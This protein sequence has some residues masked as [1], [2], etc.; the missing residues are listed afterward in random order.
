MV[1]GVELTVR[2]KVRDSL[3][4]AMRPSRLQIFDATTEAAI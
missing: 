3:R 2:A 1:P 4:L